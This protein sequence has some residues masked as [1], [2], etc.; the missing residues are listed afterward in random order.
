MGYSPATRETLQKFGARNLYNSNSKGLGKIVRIMESSN[1]ES[2]VPIRKNSNNEEPS[3]YRGNTRSNFTHFV[4]G[5]NF[6]SHFSRY[7]IL[8]FEIQFFG[9]RFLEI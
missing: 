7:G 9:I 4:A 5:K 2:L 3:S 8:S 6:Q 1:T